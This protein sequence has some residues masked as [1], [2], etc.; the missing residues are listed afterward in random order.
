MIRIDAHHHLWRLPSGTPDRTGPG[1]RAH[2]WLDGPELAPIRRDFTL[3]DLSAVAAV[4]EIDRTV[5]VQVL[6]EVAETE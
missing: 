4:A 5:L 2:D 3:D 6:P 1:P